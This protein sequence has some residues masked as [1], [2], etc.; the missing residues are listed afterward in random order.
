MIARYREDPTTATMMAVGVLLLI[1]SALFM[2][3]APPPS[4][5]G[6]AVKKRDAEFKVKL[7]TQKAQ[8]ALGQSNAFIAMRTWPESE[9]QISATVLARVSQFARN[10]GIKLIQLRPQR[11]DPKAVPPQLPF[12]VTV[13]G[14]YPSVVQFAR[15]LEGSSTKLVV[16]LVTL[17]SADASTDKVTGTIGL[18]AY[19]KP[20]K[21]EQPTPP[22]E[23]QN[24]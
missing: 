12:L 6:L 19:M 9:D 16:N 3:L 8:Q 21:P 23:K 24:A 5:A 20:Q 17:S 22:K 2:L 4:T 13:E 14:A 10:R 7:E 15:D 18:V 1:G 11:S